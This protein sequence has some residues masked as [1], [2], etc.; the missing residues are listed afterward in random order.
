M[1]P[2]E[3]EAQASSV[4]LPAPEKN[5]NKPTQRGHLVNSGGQA[6]VSTC[7]D[8]PVQTCVSEKG[9]RHGVGECSPCDSGQGAKLREFQN[10]DKDPSGQNTLKSKSRS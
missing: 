10:E 6:R 9:T 5:L 2:V 1:Y 7:T 4:P 8:D 3:Q